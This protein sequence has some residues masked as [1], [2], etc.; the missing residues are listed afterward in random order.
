MF[1]DP[2]QHLLST[3]HMFLLD[4]TLC[5]IKWH[6]TRSLQYSKGARLHMYHAVKYIVMCCPPNFSLIALLKRVMQV[7]Q[8]NATAMKIECLIYIYI[9]TY[10]SEV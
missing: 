10:I 2:Y 9:Y 3:T 5:Q 1:V 4:F 6:F 7:Y 8:I